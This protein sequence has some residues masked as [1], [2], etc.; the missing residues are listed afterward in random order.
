MASNYSEFIRHSDIIAFKGRKHVLSNFY[1]CSIFFEERW[2]NCVEQAYQWAK[3]VHHDYLDV[4]NFILSLKDPYAIRSSTKTITV[5][6]DWLTKRTHCM[7][8]ILKA[9][10]EY[11]PEYKHLLLISSGTI[12]EAVPCETFWSCG[13]SK[14]AVYQTKPSEW[15]GKNMLGILHMEVRAELKT[16]HS[17]LKSAQQQIHHKLQ[18]ELDSGIEDVSIDLENVLVTI[19]SR[20]LERAYLFTDGLLI[21]RQAVRVLV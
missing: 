10:L 18:F 8:N 17:F 19:Y 2:F 5:N 14:I 6:N 3:A 9:K 16:L 15:T 1:P 11:V 7:K 4:A 12:A 20:D 21:P 13:L